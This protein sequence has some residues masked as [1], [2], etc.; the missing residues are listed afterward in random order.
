MRVILNF[1]LPMV[2]SIE[3]RRYRSFRKGLIQFGFVMCQESM[4]TK[5][6][7][8]ST[9]VKRVEKYLQ[10]IKPDVGQIEY[11]VLTEKQYARRIILTGTAESE[12]IQTTERQIIL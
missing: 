4:Y 10:K 7:L 1:D 3:K 12:Y 6:C 5:L 2:T 9:Q 8:N 11:F